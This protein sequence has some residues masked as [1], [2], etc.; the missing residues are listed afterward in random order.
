M[1]EIDPV[2]YGKLISKVDIMGERITSMDQDIK[3]LLE[4][5]NKSKG[6][7]CDSKSRYVLVIKISMPAALQVSINFLHNIDTFGFKSEILRELIIGFRF[8]VDL[9]G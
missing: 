3:A 8:K 2:E 7:F 5:A 1:S 6:G 4:L 9:H